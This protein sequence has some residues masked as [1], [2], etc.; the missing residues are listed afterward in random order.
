[1]NA[2]YSPPHDPTWL[3]A[4]SS[5]AK[6]PMVDLLEEWLPHWLPSH[7][8]SGSVPSQIWRKCDRIGCHGSWVFLQLFSGSISQDSQE[9][10]LFP[11]LWRRDFPSRMPRH[12]SAHPQAYA[13]LPTCGKVA[14]SGRTWNLSN[15]LCPLGLL[16]LLAFS[17]KAAARRG[18]FIKTLQAPLRAGAGAISPG[19]RLVT[20]SIHI[21]WM[22]E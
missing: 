9:C 17:G 19:A 4:G 5:G 22:N 1:M 3:L 16:S 8:L 18:T 15:E 10:C 11:W 6:M 14:E 20:D 12:Q 21:C 7:S 13:Q 2:I